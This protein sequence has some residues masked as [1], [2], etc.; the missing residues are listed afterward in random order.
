MKLVCPACGATASAEAWANDAD[1]RRALAAL[2][3]LPK[4]VQPVS[5]RYLALF[6]PDQRA[7]P[8]AR[9]VKLL[10]EL[11]SLIRPGYVSIKGQVDRDCPPT[12]WAEA[13]EKMAANPTLSR[14]LKNHNYLRQVAWALAEGRDRRADQ[15]RREAEARHQPVET[16]GEEWDARWQEKYGT[17]NGG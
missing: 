1:A 8:W 10:E 16:D 15:A 6:R 9:A 3:N 5:F 13:I 17:A 11:K 14:P 12:L 7:L 2:C 4:E